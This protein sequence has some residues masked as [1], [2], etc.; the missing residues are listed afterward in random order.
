MTKPNEMP[1][2]LRQRSNTYV[3][4]ALVNRSADEIEAIVKEFREFLGIEIDWG[5]IAGRPVI[6]WMPRYP[7]PRGEPDD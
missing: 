5:Y 4:F 3:S 2:A 1:D 7:E 6:S